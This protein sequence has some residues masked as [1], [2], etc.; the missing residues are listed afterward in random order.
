[1]KPKRIEQPAPVAAKV[2]DLKAYREAHPMQATPAAAEPTIVDVYVRW[3][4][5]AGAVWAFW[6]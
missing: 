6:W 5:L 4:A 2:I 3:L 1:M